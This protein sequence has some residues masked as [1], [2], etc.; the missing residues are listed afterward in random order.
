MIEFLQQI[1]WLEMFFNMSRQFL[2]FSG[3][4]AKLFIKAYVIVLAIRLNYVA[5]V[6]KKK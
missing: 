5:F 2:S 3:D 1:E 6:E 4:V